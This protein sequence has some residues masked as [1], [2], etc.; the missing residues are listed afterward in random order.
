MKK[1]KFYKIGFTLIELLVVVAIIAILAAMLLPALSK[2][3]ERAR[4]STCMNNLKQLGLAFLMYAEDYDGWIMCFANIYNYGLPGRNVSG[5]AYLTW[6]DFLWR[7]GYVKVT[8]K[9]WTTETGEPT[10]YRDYG[11]GTVFV[12]PSGKIDRLDIGGRTY[13]MNRPSLWLAGTQYANRYSTAAGTQWLNI[14]KL[15]ISSYYIICGDSAYVF[16]GGPQ[17][18]GIQWYQIDNNQASTMIGAPTVRHL[19]FGNFLFADGHVEAMNE[20]QLRGYRIPGG[21]PNK[22]FSVIAK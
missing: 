10:P 13:G 11:K 4:A 15:R 16:S 6:C 5:T 18:L 8:K 2:A 22:Y 9:P 20:T 17:Y 21:D 19:G 14:Q 7:L 12:C 1:N 3:R